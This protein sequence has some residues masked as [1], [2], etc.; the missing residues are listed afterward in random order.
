MF[1][2]AMLRNIQQTALYFYLYMFTK[3]DSSYKYNYGIPSK[4]NDIDGTI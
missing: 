3:E 2:D 4:I 1:V